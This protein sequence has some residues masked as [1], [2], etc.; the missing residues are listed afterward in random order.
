MYLPVSL[1]WEP[2]HL[3][4]T[5]QNITKEQNLIHKLELSVAKFSIFQV[6]MMLSS[7]LTRQRIITNCNSRTHE[8]SGYDISE[9]LCLHNS[10]IFQ[11][12]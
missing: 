3:I 10:E 6:L 4:G 11:L 1:K 7:L 12:I 8:L 9:L 2:T 5:F